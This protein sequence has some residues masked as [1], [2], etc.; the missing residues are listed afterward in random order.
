MKILTIGGATQDITFHT[1]EGILVKNSQ[2]LLRQQ[3]LGFE[4]K[5]KINIPQ[6][7][8][9][10]GGG[11]ANT[12]INFSNLGN[13]VSTLVCLGD[14]SIGQTILQNF[15]DYK[16]STNLIQISGEKRTA[17]SCIINAKNLE[18]EHVL[19]TYR[20]ANEELKIN[21]DKLIPEQKFDLLYLA[22]LS[23][24][25]HRS[26]LSKI[27]R[28]KNN[29]LNQAALAWNPG[30]LQ[31]QLGLNGLKPYLQ[32]TDIFLVNKDEA[33]EICAS[34]TEK[35]N[36]KL[37]NPR[38]LLKILSKSCPGIVVITDGDNGAYALYNKKIYFE[39]A[40]KMREKDT[41]GVGDAFCSTFSWAVY[42]THFDIQKSLNL[43]V[44]NAAAV[45]KKVG[46]QNGLLSKN[47]LLSL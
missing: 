19:F 13:T 43:A 47:Q 11:A 45:L 33:I 29:K 44:K 34:S 21:A 27:F 4:L 42:S 41:T 32:K 20:G 46:A 16:I 10:F 26:N 30:N 18:Q 40:L 31:I 1:K 8:F 25:N 35:V 9:T 3:L 36:H 23:G 17:I 5:A 6:A 37:T 22:S 2:D 12:A 39:P 24:K 15:K 7:N 14:D 28:Y 38:D